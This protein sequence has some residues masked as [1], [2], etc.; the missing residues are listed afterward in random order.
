VTVVGCT[1]LWR[2]E[3]QGFQR[4][5]AGP[6][7]FLGMGVIMWMLCVLPAFGQAVPFRI[8]QYI[9]GGFVIRAQDDFTLY[10]V[11]FDRGRCAPYKFNDDTK[12]YDE[13][14]NR[15]NISP[16]DFPMHIAFGKQQD[17]IAL[18]KNEPFK[19]GTDQGMEDWILPNY[20]ASNYGNSDVVEVIIETD[21][22][23]F[24]WN[25]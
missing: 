24:K 21:K 7:N 1:A 8:N 12:Q 18:V 25:P 15:K 17:I 10:G 5:I 9:P 23:T 14:D 16:I 11:D 6:G 3:R 4:W 13:K 19:N 20:C 22:G 2:S